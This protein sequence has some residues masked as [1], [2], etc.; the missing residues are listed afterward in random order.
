MV[1]VYA[2]SLRGREVV[3]DKGYTIGF[4]FDLVINE[5]NGKI[6]ALICEPAEEAEQP[7]T[8]QKLPRDKMGNIIV[9]YSAVKSMGGMI[10]VSEKLL[11]IHL[12]KSG[13]LK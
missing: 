7:V 12:L 10:L 3:S 11:K 2:S 1:R 8:V 5:S 6:I 4:L 13:R 9:P